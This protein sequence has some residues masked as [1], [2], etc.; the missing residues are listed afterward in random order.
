ME[1]VARS[2][3][4]LGA[5]LSG[6]R[7]SVPSF[8]GADRRVLVSGQA[9]GPTRGVPQVPRVLAAARDG[10]QLRHLDEGRPGAASC[11]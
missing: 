5:R 9:D 8:A 1:V 2:G 10:G 4:M 11:A 7:V 3:T 6:V